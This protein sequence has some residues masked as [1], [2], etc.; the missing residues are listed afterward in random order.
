MFEKEMT[1][2]NPDHDQKLQLVPVQ[3]ERASHSAR[4]WFNQ[5]VMQRS[6]GSKPGWV[7]LPD[8]VWR[9]NSALLMS[10]HERKEYDG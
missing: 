10:M 1:M 2:G 4:R 5:I 8:R 6:R 9:R 7:H 3:S